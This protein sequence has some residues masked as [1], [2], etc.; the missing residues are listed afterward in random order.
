MT[1][2]VVNELDQVFK[3]TIA[4]RHTTHHLWSV[5]SLAAGGG[6]RPGE[7]R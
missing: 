7:W 3:D 6:T 4:L 2:P 5:V 1:Q